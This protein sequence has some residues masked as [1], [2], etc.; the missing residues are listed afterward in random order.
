VVDVVVHVVGSSE[1][2]GVDDFIDDNPGSSSIEPSEPR[3]IITSVPIGYTR[4]IE[5]CSNR[6]RI[7]LNPSLQIMASGTVGH[8]SA[9]L[10][11]W[12]FHSACDT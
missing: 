6:Y 1:S 10:S 3:S 8:P 2:D 12:V 11:L 9:V 5:P 7:N 4:R